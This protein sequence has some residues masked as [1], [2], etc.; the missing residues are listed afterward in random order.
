[1]LYRCAG[2]PVLAQ[3]VGM[4]ITYELTQKDFYDSM[5]AHRNR[6]ALQKW[7]FRITVFFGLVLG[8]IGLLLAALTPHTEALTNLVPLAAVA[9][10]WAVLMC[11]LPWWSARRQYRKQPSSQGSRTLA[12]D[13]TGVHWRWNGG[14]SDVEWKNYIRY[15]ESKRQFLLYLSPA[16]FNMVPKRALTPEQVSEFRTLLA[17]NISRCR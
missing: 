9:F 11:G 7:A 2:V 6:S 4:E 14:A 17:Q 10:G 12:M 16:A 3:S 15:V 8:G 5:I 1:M 13:A